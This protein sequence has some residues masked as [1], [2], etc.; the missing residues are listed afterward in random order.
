MSWG[1]CYGSCSAASVQ[2]VITAAM[3]VTASDYSH[4]YS[5][6]LQLPWVQQ[7]LET[8]TAIWVA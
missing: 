5:L 3:A 2:Y 1:S 7:C 8:S 6:Q 4:G